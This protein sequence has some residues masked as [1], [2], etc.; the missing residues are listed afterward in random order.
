MGTDVSSGPIF[1]KKKKKK[2][3]QTD[4]KPC[5]RGAYCLVEETENRW[6]KYVDYMS[7]Q[8]ILC[9]EKN[10]RKGRL[11][12]LGDK[13]RGVIPQLQLKGRTP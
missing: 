1:L 11:E 6:N 3:N 4:T 10:S 12:M 2:K 9:Y 13:K 5:P 7:Q 8:N